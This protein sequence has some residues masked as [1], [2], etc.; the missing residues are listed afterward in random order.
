MGTFYPGGC[1]MQMQIRGGRAATLADAIGNY[2][3]WGKR[4]VWFH[5]SS[6]FITVYTAAQTN[7]K[8]DKGLKY[9]IDNIPVDEIAGK[10]TEQ[11]QVSIED[12][13][14]EFENLKV[15]IEDLRALVE[16]LRGN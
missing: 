6:R 11:L 14:Q 10:A 12:L 16:E 8:I 5:G 9:A 2:N 13:Q 15:E 1:E 7:K 3:A 4:Y